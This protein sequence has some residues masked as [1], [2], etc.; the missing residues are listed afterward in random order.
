[1]RRK[2]T[3]TAAAGE[4]EGAEDDV[5]EAPANAVDALAK[6]TKKAEA[7]V[8][9]TDAGAGRL[10]KP[11]GRRDAPGEEGTDTSASPAKKMR[12]GGEAS[13]EKGTGSEKGIADKPEDDAGTE[14]DE[15]IPP[16]PG[17][18]VKG[19]KPI[20]PRKKTVAPARTVSMGVVVASQSRR[21]DEP[22]VPTPCP[23]CKQVFASA[24]LLQSH[25]KSDTCAGPH[26]CKE[27]DKTFRKESFLRRHVSDH[28]P[29]L[30]HAA[31]SY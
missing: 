8:K 11:P 15:E 27:C 29:R 10:K 17:D 26:V 13:K 18:A 3:L 30:C 19:A 1:M 20:I 24:A 28:L 31:T 22:S 21:S 9:S 4:N 12:T 5:P 6:A 7:S 2:R 25:S 23:A 14:S 16:A